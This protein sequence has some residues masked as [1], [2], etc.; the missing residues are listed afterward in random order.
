MRNLLFG[1]MAVIILMG[2]DAK[3]QGKF[4]GLMFGDYFYNVARDTTFRR[5]NLSNSAVSG[6]K[7]LQG[8]Q[9][10]R[11]YFTY[12]NDISEKFTTRFRL[13]AD[14]AA[15]S[16]NGKISTY[17]KD[18]YLKWKNIFGGSDL[19]FGLQ[20]T[21]AYEIS[22]NAWGYRSLEKTI[23]D[24]RG[25]IPSRH[26]GISLKGKLDEG[27]SVNYWLMF[28]NNSTSTSVPNGTVAGNDKFKRY[29]LHLQFKPSDKLQI[30]LYG[31][32]LARPQVNDPKSTAVPRA[33]LS[34]DAITG[35][36]FVGYAEKDKYNFGVE[37]F[38][39]STANQFVNATGS[40]AA[41]S[42]LGITVFGTV[43]LQQDLV[44]IA[45]YDYF[46]P[47]TSS[48]AKGD[49]RNYILAGLSFKVD[50]NV[51]I[52]P[53]VQLETYEAVPNGPSLDPSVTGRITF[54]YNFL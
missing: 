19:T 16:S 4:S 44:L 11:I 23:M 38:L 21:P 50:K 30:T 35:A 8:F 33:T 7:D 32:L 28:A 29:S 47:N 1:F 6:Q 24:L 54:Y 25:I 49:M 48:D 13:E 37:G 27:G 39:N 26:L 5:T 31:D 15:L 53:N 45:R 20:P 42:A 43:N 36:V 34:N 17:V 9:F 14:Q 22:E 51:Q 2:V 10:R 41:L 46:D 12:D 18:A 40:P 3:S 52:I